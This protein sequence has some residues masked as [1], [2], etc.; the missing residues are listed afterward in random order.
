MVRQSRDYYLKLTVTSEIRIPKNIIDRRIL[1]GVVAQWLA[2]RISSTRIMRLVVR[3]LL[4]ALIILWSERRWGSVMGA[5]LCSPLVHSAE[6]TRICA[7]GLNEELSIAAKSRTT[8]VIKYGLRS[9]NITVTGLLFE[10]FDS[11][12]CCSAVGIRSKILLRIPTAVQGSNCIKLYLRVKLSNYIYF[13][14]PENIF[15]LHKFKHNSYFT[16]TKF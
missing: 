12:H 1:C 6:C 9:L 16:S 4:W 5:R 8:K 15:F 7:W 14:T 2:P 11:C 10:S 3:I 13:N